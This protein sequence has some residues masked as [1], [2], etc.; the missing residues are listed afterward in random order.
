MRRYALIILLSIVAM[1]LMGFKSGKIIHQPYSSLS[2]IY[3]SEGIIVST[4]YAMPGFTAD[5]GNFYSSSPIFSYTR[6]KGQS[7]I[8]TGM[9]PYIYNVDK[10]D[11]L[12]VFADGETVYQLTSDD[13]RGVYAAII[14]S[15][16]II[17]ITDKGI[18]TLGTFSDRGINLLKRSGRS[19]FLAVENDLYSID[20]NEINHICTVNDKNI[21]AVESYGSSII[22]GTEGKGK[23]IELK[24]G[25]QHVMFT[26]MLGEIDMIVKT[27]DHYTVLLNKKNSANGNDLLYNSSLL[28]IN[29]Q[30][31]D[32]MY[33]TDQFIISGTA[34]GSDIVMMRAQIP[35]LLV[36][37]DEELF[38]A[39]MI[40]S[41]Y[42]LS[43]GNYN[44]EIIIT[45]GDPGRIYTIKPKDGTYLYESDIID[46]GND[47]K[48]NSIHVEAAGKGRLYIRQ[49]DS[50]DIGDSWNEYMLVKP[51]MTLTGDMHRFVQYKYVF[52]E[53][54]DKLFDVS[55]YYRTV[56]HAPQF[57]SLTIYAPRILPDYIIPERMNIYPV[58]NTAMY[59]EYQNS[60]IKTDRKVIFCMWSATDRDGDILTY[61]VYMKNRYGYLPVKKGVNEQYALVYIDGFDQGD[62]ELVVEA[63]DSISNP[64]NAMK[65]EISEEIYIDNTAPVISDTKYEK[66]LLTFRVKDNNSFIDE[67]YYSVN[68]SEMRSVMP[69]DGIYD[70]NE[71]SFTVKIKKTVNEDLLIA[72]Y[73]LDRFGNIARETKLVR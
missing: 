69:D 44:G 30:A 22:I 58:T 66:N 71:E 14:P 45:T 37:R 26:S 41:D 68:G 47:I 29:N 17:L 9:I 18:D 38:S 16:N 34:Y 70:S 3:V 13:S 32:T 6:Y 1:G 33:S 24:G 28:R 62:Y 51:G 10:Q 73:V 72:L 56:N 65:A 61:N 55:M 25:K 21:S 15:G 12:A 54:S 63:L 4:E 2:E 46:M 52:S 50:F 48:I 19:I 40:K 60:I 42:M 64:D 59:P 20:G 35:E 31:V 11:T 67:M 36:L 23:L 49:G 7:I 53:I 39:G 57:D 43:I 8:G 5:T 27:D